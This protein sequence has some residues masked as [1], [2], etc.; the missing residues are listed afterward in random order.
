M[1]VNEILTEEIIEND[2]VEQKLAWKRSG[3]K[4]S[5]KYRCGSGHRKGRIV[6]KASQCFAP[7]DL[8]KR[9]NLRKTKAKK[10]AMMIRKAKK[11]KKWNAASRRVSKLNRKR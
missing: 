9:F 2:I 11:T 1:L 4:V 3:T 5:Q 7:P 6:A 10:G 8:K